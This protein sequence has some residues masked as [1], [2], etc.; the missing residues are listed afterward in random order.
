MQSS[1]ALGRAGAIQAAVALE[2]SSDV[3]TSFDVAV[4]G[5]NGQLP[6]LDLV[7][8]F[9]AFCQ[10]NGL[11]C[12]IQGK[13]R[14]WRW[15]R[16]GA[17]AGGPRAPSDTAAPQLQRSDWDTLPAYAHSLQTLLLM[18]LKQGSGRPQ[19]DHGLFLRY[20]IE[21]ITVR[22]INSFRQY[23]YDMTTVGK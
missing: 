15:W 21:A 18:V 13:V 9:H 10:K 5:L 11:L 23:K 6:N 1:G 16:R 22:G 14:C 7:N 8:L 19:G 20:H 17:G 2:L 12:T 4:E 3:V